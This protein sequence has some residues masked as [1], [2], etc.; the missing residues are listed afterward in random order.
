MSLDGPTYPADAGAQT[1]LLTVRGKPVPATVDEARTVHNATAGAPPS[2]AGARALGD[3]S[4]N[5]FVGAGDGADGDI[6]FVDFWNSL[7]GLGQFF[8]NP[9]VQAGAGQLFATRDGTVWAG[10]DGF[11]DFHLATPA[12][13]SARGL[14]VI[15]TRVTS[16]EAA[17]PAFAAYA[18]AT[19]NTART[20]GLVSHTTW[21]RVPDP[22]AE[23]VAE[24]IGID[25][26]LDPEEMNRY[27]ALGLGFEHLGRVFDGEPQ[28]SSW[29]AAPGDW[30]EW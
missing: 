8:A 25:Q 15:R 28:S 5:V 30:V 23:P 14:G 9:D 27:C 18:A 24:V 16:I 6:L 10:T 20:H 19:I 3:L 13:S 29:Q 12:G 11:G 1:F 26:W 7:T 4:H 21:V 2:V 17:A 22:G